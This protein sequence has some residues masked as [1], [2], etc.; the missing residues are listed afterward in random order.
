MKRNELDLFSA[1]SA[2]ARIPGAWLPAPAKTIPI[3]ISPFTSW[4]GL[5]Q[6]IRFRAFYVTA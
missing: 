3:F 5:P 4:L 1:A 2:Q 6:G